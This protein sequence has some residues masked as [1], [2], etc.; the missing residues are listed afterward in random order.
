MAAE[1]KKLI[2]ELYEQL[3]RT[4]YT[5]LC[6]FAQKYIPDLDTCKEIVHNVF[7]NIWE[8]REEFDFEKPA[9]SYL[10]TAV[11]N[12]CLNHIRNQKKFVNEL[13]DSEKPSAEVPSI[14]QD[15]LEAAELEAKIWDTINL[16]PEKCREV[17][18][19]NRFEGKKYGE[20]AEQLGISVKTVEA[21][22]SKALR[23]LREHLQEYIT[24][25]LFILLNELWKH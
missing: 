4:Y 23:T 18:I 6:Y 24:I 3:F 9:K 16:L 22:M 20:I 1:K 15:H 10:F 13:T 19:L 8:K 2:D 12:R 14:D 21:Q 11:Y 7:V 25:M 17:F 5:A